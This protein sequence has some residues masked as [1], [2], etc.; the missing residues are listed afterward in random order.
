MTPPPPPPPSP[1]PPPPSPPPQ[2][3]VI[4]QNSHGSNGVDRGQKVRQQMPFLV[5]LFDTI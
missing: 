2:V 3:I 5:I 1:P 4:A